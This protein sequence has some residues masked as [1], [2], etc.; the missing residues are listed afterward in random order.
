MKAVIHRFITLDA[1]NVIPEVYLGLLLIYAVLLLTTLNSIRTQTISPAR[2]ILW[3]LFVIMTPMAG[4]AIY[5]LICIM[6]A[7]HSF[8]RSIGLIRS[9]TTATFKAN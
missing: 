6:T 4:M 3:A 9:N 7:D 1:R 5:A 8:L 2:K